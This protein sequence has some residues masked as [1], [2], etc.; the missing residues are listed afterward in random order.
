[1]KQKS[2]YLL[3]A[4]LNLLIFIS[5]LSGCIII[6]FKQGFTMLM[7]YTV[8]S[9]ILA[10]LASLLVGIYA[11][12]AYK[13][14]VKIPESIKML[15]Y[16]SVCCLTVTFIVVVLVLAPMN[17]IKGYQMMLFSGDMLFHHL[18]S[19]VLSI[20]TFLMF[21]RVSY[22]N[23]KSAS[24]ALIP[25]IIYAVI[26]ITLNLLRIV[27]GPYPFLRVYAQPFYLSLIW[28]ILIVGGAYL[29]AYGLAKSKPCQ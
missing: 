23:S 8:D 12:K 4:V 18:I 3:E 6:Y 24:F 28:F 25:T 7:F 17:G 9:N 1:M 13:S 16:V 15:K 27:E 5:S 2:K 21:D 19:P 20:L 14:G 22:S 10:L 11:L 26:L 29:I